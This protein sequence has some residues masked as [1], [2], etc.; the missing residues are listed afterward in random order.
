MDVVG[1]APSG[2]SAVWETAAQIRAKFDH[3]AMA[4]PR[5]RDLLPIYH[6]LLGGRFRLGGDNVV[7]GY[8]GVQLTFPD[9]R[10]VE[11][12]EPLAGSAFLERFFAR[13]GGGGF[14]HVT[15]EVDD[16]PRALAEI[17]KTTLRVEAVR[18]DSMSRPEAFLHPG[19]THGCLIQLIQPDGSPPPAGLTLD[20]VLAGH[21]MS[22]NGIPSP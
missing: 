7:A 2:G 3:I 13:T 19:R 8:R 6:D 4:A 22:G 10:V 9:D 1:G 15:F 12:L 21:G 11:L 5:L 16:L 14:H 17:E 20:R 18:L